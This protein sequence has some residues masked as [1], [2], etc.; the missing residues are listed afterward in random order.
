VERRNLGTLALLTPTSSL[1]SKG[2]L[3]TASIHQVFSLGCALV[4][5]LGV[6]LARTA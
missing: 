1:G 4:W 2:L 5:A 6:L 3:G